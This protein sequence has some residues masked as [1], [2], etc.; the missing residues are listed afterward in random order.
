MIKRNESKFGILL[1][2]WIF[3]N[4]KKLKTGT[5]EIKQT[6]GS[7]IPFSSVEEHQVDYSLAIKHS[8]KGAFVRVE[9]GTVGAPDYIFLKHEPAYIAIRFPDFFCIIDIDRFCMEKIE[10]KRKSLT[11]DRA[12]AIAFAVVQMK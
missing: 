10:N 9:A 11:A 12:K 6:Q 8:E 2:H 3:A 1:R 7:S 5:F 4:A